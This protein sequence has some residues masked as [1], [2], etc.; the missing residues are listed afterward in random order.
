VL[1]PDGTYHCDD[2]YSGAENLNPWLSLTPIEGTYN[3][4]VGSFS[5]DVMASGT[6]TITGEAG[7]TPVPL[8]S[9]DIQQ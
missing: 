5:P 6:L 3:V 8:T 2:D 4:W 9:T 1:A 7:A